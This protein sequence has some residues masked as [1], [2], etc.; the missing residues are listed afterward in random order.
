MLMEILQLTQMD[1]PQPLDQGQS[2]KI[3]CLSVLIAILM[4]LP[5]C[6]AIMTYQESY[7]RLIT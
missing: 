7:A 4:L 5:L 3:N 6:F 2:D 1:L